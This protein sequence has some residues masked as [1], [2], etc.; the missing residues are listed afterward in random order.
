MIAKFCRKN[1]QKLQHSQNNETELD[2]NKPEHNI[3][4]K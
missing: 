3:K 2:K 4:V 1:P